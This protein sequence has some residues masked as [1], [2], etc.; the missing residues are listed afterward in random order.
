MDMKTAQ[1]HLAPKN[2]EGEVHV[3]DGQVLRLDG[4]DIHEW[5]ARAL[6]A[7]GVPEPEAPPEPEMEPDQDAEPEGEEADE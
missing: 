6:A 2:K 5:R 7:E 1:E 3:V 4:L